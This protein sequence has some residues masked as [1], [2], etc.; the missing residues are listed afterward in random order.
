MTTRASSVSASSRPASLTKW[1]L[2]RP[3]R[4]L[5]GVEDGGTLFLLGTDRLGRDMLSRII[6]GARISL[7]VGL[8]G[9]A[10]SF[11]L[12]LVFGGLSGY[13]GGTIDIVIQR[14]IE[15]IRAFPELPLW[16]ALSAALPP[17][18]DPILVYSGITVI[19]GVLEWTGLARSIR[20]SSCPCARRTSPPP[21]CSWAAPP[22]TSSGG[23]SC[24]RS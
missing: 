16:M 3:E 13:Y 18:W 11:V 23:T 12:A 2:W 19:L 7:T 5:V 1:G 24:P 17:R 22:P 14:F 20:S 4:H 10:V 21:P 8:L 6:H 9:I 15:V